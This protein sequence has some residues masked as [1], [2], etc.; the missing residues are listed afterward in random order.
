MPSLKKTRRR[1]GTWVTGHSSHAWF[2]VCADA[3]QSA[4]LQNSKSEIST[5]LSCSPVW[6]IECVSSVVRAPTRRTEDVSQRWPTA[7]QRTTGLERRRRSKVHA[8]TGTRREIVGAAT[9]TTISKFCRTIRPTVYKR[10]TL[11]SALPAASTRP[12]TPQ[13][14]D[15]ERK[16]C[17]QNNLSKPPTATPRVSPSRPPPSQSRLLPRRAQPSLRQPRPARSVAPQ[18]RPRASAPP[19]RTRHRPPCPWPQICRRGG[20]GRAAGCAA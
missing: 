12:Q 14:R 20:A 7:L 2:D 15:A 6:M 8:R 5:R 16:K 19:P 4:P 10:F 18:S 11:H 9:C 3:A 17:E 13:T 1:V